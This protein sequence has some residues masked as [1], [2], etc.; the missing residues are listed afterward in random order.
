[1][2]RKVMSNDK[3]PRRF[4]DAFIR[5]EKERL[6]T[7]RDIFREIMKS[8]QHKN[9]APDS[10]GDLSMLLFDKKPQFKEEKL[11]EV[12]GLI[13]EFKLAPLVVS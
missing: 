10:N 3:K 8:M 12:L 7:Y 4:S 9:F 6:N 2:V 5:E 11:K 13:K 1:M